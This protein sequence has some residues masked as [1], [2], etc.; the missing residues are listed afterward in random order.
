[1]LD[2]PVTGMNAEEVQIIMKK[3]R[4][5]R[6]QG[7]TILLVEHNIRSVMEV[8]DRICVL[9]F[10]NKIAEGTPLEIS[11]NPEVIKAY[12]GTEYVA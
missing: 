8:C 5:L 2:E 6:K 12:L 1:M 7:I 10:G 11:K 3:I 9:N 4:D